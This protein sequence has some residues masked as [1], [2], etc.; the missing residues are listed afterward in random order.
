MEKE[1]KN[2][3]KRGICFALYVFCTT[4]ANQ[5]LSKIIIFQ[6]NN[7]NYEETPSFV[8]RGLGWFRN[9]G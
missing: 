3:K 7:N 4:F 9:H 5:C 2:L 6:Q 8:R 1:C